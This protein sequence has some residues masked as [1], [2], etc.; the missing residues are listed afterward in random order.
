MFCATHC[1]FYGNKIIT[2]QTFQQE[3]LCLIMQQ[4]MHY[5]AQIF[6]SAVY[7]E[8]FEQNP[9]ILCNLKG[10]SHEIGKACVWFFR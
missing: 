1:Y 8:K 5:C 6:Y 10:Q 9:H 7:R 3:M 4:S 2:L